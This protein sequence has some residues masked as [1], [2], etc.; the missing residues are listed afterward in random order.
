MKRRKRSWRKR[1]SLF[2]AKKRLSRVVFGF[3]NIFPKKLR[4]GHYLMV[5]LVGVVIAASV[6]MLL[7][8]KMVLGQTYLLTQNDWSG[9]A[10][11]DTVNAPANLSGWTKYASSSNVTAGVGSVALTASQTNFSDSFTTTAN[12][13]MGN[14]TANWNT[15]TGKIEMNTDTNVDLTTPA[16][17]AIIP[18][19]YEIYS[20]VLDPVNN[21]IYLSGA[22]NADPG[23]ACILVKY[24]IASGTI[25]DLSAAVNAAV[26]SCVSQDYSNYYPI[27]MVYYQPTGEI[28]V[29]VTNSGISSALFFKVNTATA[30][31]TNMT[32]VMCPALSCIGHSVSMTVD[33]D[34]GAIYLAALNRGLG[35][36]V[37]ASQTATDLSSSYQAIF[38]YQTQVFS[39]VYS[40]SDHAVYF[41]GNYNSNPSFGKYIPGTNTFVDLS[42]VI[43]STLGWS[44]AYLNF[45]AY[46]PV[47]SKIYL[48]TG[49]S[50]TKFASYT[51]AGVATDLS[52]LFSDPLWTL[53]GLK[54]IVYSSA[55]D[56]VFISSSQGNGFYSAV[57]G[58][59]SVYQGYDY[60]GYDVS[61]DSTGTM[62]FFGGNSY[63]KLFFKSTPVCT[64]CVATSITIDTTTQNIASA[65][66]TKT[67]TPGTGTV[68]Y[69]LSNDGGAHYNTV[70]PSS[71]YTFATVGSDLRFKL[72]LT[73]NATVSDIAIAYNYFPASGSLTS[74]KFDSADASNIINLL[75]WVESAS[76]PAGTTATVSIRSAPDSASLTGAWTDR[77]N[78]SSGCSKAT[79]IVTCGASAIPAGMQDGSGD[80]WFQYMIAF[81][82][83]GRNTPTVSSLSM[84][85]VINIAPEVRNVTASQNADGTVTIHYE[86]RDID[87]AGGSLANRD[88]ITPMFEY[89]DGSA[90]QTMTTLAAHD[91]DHKAVAHDGSWNNTTYTA[92]WTPSADFSGHLMNNT[93]KVR[94]TANDG[95]GAN[96]T[97]S[98]ES[99]TYSL[100]TQV[101]TANSISVDASAGV[102]TVHLHSEDSSAVS[103]QVSSTDPT[104]ASTA[105]ESFSATKTNLVITEGTTV[106]A[107]FTDAF[108]NST[109]ILS[110]TVPAILTSVMIQDTS[111]VIVTP[112]VYRL[113][114]AWKAATGSFSSYKVHRST[115]LANPENWDEVGSVG[116]EATN[117]FVDTSVVENGHYYYY[118]D[119]VDAI[120]SIS[121][122]SLVVDGIADGTQSGGEGGGGIGPAPAISNVSPGTPSSTAATITWDT[123]ALSDSVVQYSISPSTFTTTVTVGALVNND[124]GVG[125]H[126][127]ILSGLTPNKPYYFR[128]SS[129]DIFGQPTV[130]DNGGIG[131]TFTTPQGPIISNTS[132]VETTNTTARITW[133]TNIP[134][135]S[136]LRRSTHSDLSAPT[137]T[138]GTSDPTLGH[139]IYLTNLSPGT[140]YFF[141]V[142]S[143]DG[144]GNETVDNRVVDGAVQYYSFTT[145][146]D[147]APPT[148]TGIS[149]RTQP[150]SVDIIWTTDKVADSQVEYGLTAAYGTSTVLDATQTTRHVVTILGLA[151]QT[152]YDFRV[153]SRGSNAVL[154]TSANQTFTTS[155]AG[156][157]TPPVISNAA[158]ASL[159]LNSASV[160]WT[161]DEPAT[162]YVDY[163]ATTDLGSSSG[164]P[165]LATSHSVTLDGLAG[166]AHYYFRVRSADA[167]GNS[168]VDNNGGAYYAFTTAADGTAPVISNPDDIISMNSFRVVW[169]TNELADSQIEYGPDAGYGK[170][171]ALDET[172]VL[173]HSVMVSSL[174]AA[175]TYHYRILTKDASG[176][177]TTGPDRVITTAVEADHTPPI[178]TA[179][180]ASSIGRT[181]ATIAWTTDE[182]STSEVL[183]GPNTFYA[184][185]T[186]KMNDNTTA[187]SVDLTG[188]TPGVKYYFKVESQD[189]SG[190]IATDDD[191]GAG[192]TFTTVI[193]NTPPVIS[194]VSTA[195]VSDVSAVIVW[196]T[197]EPASAQVVY[198]ATNAYGSQ[199]AV[200]TTLSTVHSV[201]I[202]GLTAK[203]DYFY[204]VVSADAYANSATDDNVVAG[205]TGY[206]FTTTDVPGLIIRARTPETDANP[207]NIY[208]LKLSAVKQ[209]S[210]LVS[211]TTDEN[212]YSIVKFGPDANYGSLLGSIDDNVLS[213]AVALLGLA[214][215]TTYHF[216]A[217]SADASGNKG[218]SNDQVFAT[219]NAD[220]TA[221]EIPVAL[222]P[223]ANTPAPTNDNSNTNTP[224]PAPAPAEKE[225][226]IL[227]SMS[228]LQQMVNSIMAD[229][230]SVAPEALGQTVNDLVN[231][232]IHPPALVGPKPSVEVS[233]TQAIVRWTTD[234]KTSGA[235]AFAKDADYSAKAAN[236]YAN[237]VSN[238]GAFETDHT[239][240]LINLEPAT[241]YHFQV[242]SKG[243][244]GGEAVSNDATFVTSSELPIIT[245]LSL[246]SIVDNAATLKWKTNI[247][248][249]TSIEYLNTATGETLTQGDTAL[250]QDHSFNL[251]QLSA[252]ASYKI[253]VVATDEQ[254]DK[255]E[256]KPIAVSTSKD[257]TA[258]VISKVSSSSTLYPGKESRVQTII[259]WDTD[260][261]ANSQISYQEGLATDATVNQLPLD[262]AMVA[263]HTAVITK[264]QPTTVYKFWIQSGDAAG[265]MAKSKDFLILTPQQQATILD[266]IIGNFEQ[267]FGWTN[268]LGK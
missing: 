264:F 101:P 97:G 156:D 75:I 111:N 196:T 50:N 218:F 74:S 110:A 133:T 215:G 216:M 165:A 38:G 250:L 27:S 17:K 235:V 200:T 162:S 148:F 149:A 190:N 48:A 195:L 228:S 45:M 70:T 187:H 5:A 84:Q 58:S 182:K 95:E 93:A 223:P 136:E 39:V 41:A 26:P 168:S 86:V 229:S 202:L 221:P 43:K 87:T 16:L 160:N 10:T 253:T 245:D 117:Y 209:T 173:D 161:T 67:D 244:I 189:P 114:I 143:V 121:F 118:V 198:G 191:H 24:D 262:P 226:P 34:N 135:T 8:P 177:L 247:P 206:T 225:N 246:S 179:P 11:P 239:V 227:I 55:Y 1:I 141:Y 83:D 15:S 138:T 49:Y 54:A 85:F 69:Q 13:D 197:D 72:T 154:G 33:T 119:T 116:A 222:P 219:L 99:A 169:Q 94:V 63:G 65:T 184:Y 180:T 104:L 152:A 153:R 56:G 259:T 144:S 193:D 192:L 205:H 81:T 224:T 157:A 204:K 107:R 252:G 258:P 208:N 176:N 163:G 267:V 254:G 139:E 212:S 20:N 106:Y 255:A 9:S 6:F 14:T 181:T 257:T 260:E 23:G 166:G 36:Y 68:T 90:Y 79:G 82:S 137:T 66:L 30:V 80:R 22:K 62:A 178:I 31:V 210:A 12:R 105:P 92:T 51:T 248:T 59:V 124:A 186:A 100:D 230:S 73:G 251:D 64:S 142:R 266:V 237:T 130:A 167:A 102:P 203:T 145:T 2:F 132:V 140:L 159:S 217:V 185:N 35:K 175:T 115:S 32:S 47:R 263:H 60:Y 131:F 150:T 37:V 109:G 201:T 52:S 172:L 188:L 158:V 243:T 103:M 122:R 18:A 236:P 40:T 207:P 76:M 220:G 233:G 265:N 211:W 232:L 231:K 126:R 151:P 268:K 78:A 91:T 155:Q 71:L 256:S 171:T 21:V 199:T 29:S 125:K 238:S 128:V 214:P 134:A 46:D 129:T 77:T 183:Y 25:T 249:S 4:L 234:R 240:T 174:T 53:Y 123:D 7:N 19:G 98:S 164:S 120:G 61:L 127:V 242:H 147:Q 42:S 3:K 89:W 261:P 146:N 170:T 57:M 108:N 112:H 241:T 88:H 96:A 113:F 213:H 44:S 28:F 194:G